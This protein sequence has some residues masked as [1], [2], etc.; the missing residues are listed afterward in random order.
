MTIDTDPLASLQRRIVE[1]EKERDELRK[2]YSRA[3]ATDIMAR[4][5]SYQAG[6]D[7]AGYKAC[8]ICEETCIPTCPTCEEGK[9]EKASQAYFDE[10]VEERALREKLSKILRATADALHGGPHPNGF[11]SFHDLPEL[12][13]K[14]Q[15]RLIDGEQ[16]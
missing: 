14:L 15:A 8:D 4:G 13:T 6:L 5:K 9:W 12:A 11:W 2:A 10:A 1:L 7:D 16:V 3:A